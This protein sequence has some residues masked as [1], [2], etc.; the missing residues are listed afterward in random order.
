MTKLHRKPI[1]LLLAIIVIAGA[2]GCNS[3]KS[4]PAVT[5]NPPSPVVVTSDLDIFKNDGLVKN[6]ADPFVYKDTDGTYYLYHTG[7]GFPVHTS[8]DL[9]TWTPM[10][11]SM[12]AAGYKWAEKNFWAPEVVRSGNKYYMH[13][14]AAPEDG[15]LQIGLAVADSP[16]GPFADVNNKP[17]FETGDK[18]VLDSHLFFDDDDKV[19][20]YFSNAMSTNTVGDQRYSEIWVVEVNPDLSAVKGTAKRLIKPEQS[21][22]YNNNKGDFWNEGAVVI[23][24][25]GIYYLMYSANC[26][27]AAGYSVGYATAD[28]PLGPF[29]K[30]ANNP[31]LSNEPYRYVVSGPGHHSV[32]WSPDGTEMIMV[33]HS[34]MDVSQGG[35]ERQINIDRMGFRRD[36]TLYVNGPTVTAQPAPSSAS[37]GYRDI[38][39]QAAISSPSTL[40]GSTT[41]SL[42]DGEFSMYSKFIEYEWAAITRNIDEVELS[43]SWNQ[44]QKIREVWFY[45]SVDPTRQVTTGRVVLN[46]GEPEVNVAFGKK[47]GE[48]SI[49]K[50]SAVKETTG[51]KLYLKT[52]AAKP[53]QALS[54]VKV[55]AV[56]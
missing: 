43:F 41:S 30:Y 45:N 15:I 5:E 35:G 52:A 8:K 20:L 36:G 50:F 22:E 53:V 27:C 28:S 18:G 13:Y 14:T 10:G 39:G 44:P 49:V 16:L 19:Y 32:T 9:C 29:V 42:N 3:P 6:A 17:F 47:P 46:N 24:N 23:K 26:F 4:I 37:V 34:H 1:F 40:S 33:Y 51:F 56:Q 2:Y 11:K 7:K 54:E 25:Q 31:V 21:W 38:S 12:P 55:F 48:S